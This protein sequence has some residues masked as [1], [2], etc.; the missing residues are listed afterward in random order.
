M[1]IIQPGRAKAAL[2]VQGADRIVQV[3]SGSLRC[4][5][6]FMKGERGDGAASHYLGI[7]EGMLNGSS[8]IPRKLIGLDPVGKFL[9]CYLLL[10]GFK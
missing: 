7:V 8:N 3:H 5:C 6:L 4:R 1:G 10:S 2:D 9:H